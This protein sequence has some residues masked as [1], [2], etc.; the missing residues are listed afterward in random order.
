[1][2]EPYWP[3]R[4]GPPY[5]LSDAEKVA[6]F[7]FIRCQYCKVARYV[8]LE[9]LRR[10][11]GNIE[12]DDVIYSRRWRC[13]KCNSPDMLEMDIRNPPIGKGE[14]FVIRRLDRIAT[15]SWPVWR[16]EKG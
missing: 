6:R 2:P 11:F 12:C 7:A 8:P 13:M 14:P 5:K 4:K 3:K 15:K 9:D 10:L 16:D 1:M